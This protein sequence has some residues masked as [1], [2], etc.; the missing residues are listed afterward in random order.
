MY[1]SYL[2]NRYVCIIIKSSSISHTIS[3][4]LPKHW[5][6][7]TVLNYKIDYQMIRG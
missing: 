1:I 4:K 3:N 2:Y 7:V 6:L 5:S